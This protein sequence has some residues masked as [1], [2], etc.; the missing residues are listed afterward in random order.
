MRGR[1]S[2]NCFQPPIYQR[3]KQGFTMDARTIENLEDVAEQTERVIGLTRRGV[4]GFSVSPSLARASVAREG[5][6]IEKPA[7]LT[8]A[9]RLDEDERGATGATIISEAVTTYT[10][11]VGGIQ[12][13]LGELGIRQV[14]F[15]KLAGFA[16][17]L[18]GKAFG[19]S[20]VKRLGPEKLFDAIRAAGLKL[21]LE[22]DPE[23]LERMSKQIAENCQPRQA[24]QA[25]MG[26]R[27]HLSNSTIDEVLSY[28]ANNKKGG[29]ARLNKAVRQAR[30]NHARRTIAIGVNWAQRRSLQHISEETTA[31]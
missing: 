26:N 27:S 16:E 30:S 17:G 12:Q 1:T 11:L 19:P 21:R 7:A 29:I 28:L 14:D 24:K 23:Q 9:A 22:A 5:R 15:D 6:P 20:Q 10:E 31:G 25:R 8:P 13:R 2:K 3:R 4:F 18:T